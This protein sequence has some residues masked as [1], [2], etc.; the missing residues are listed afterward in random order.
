MHMSLFFLK[1]K[2]GPSTS[3]RDGVT[4][5]GFT[6]PL[7]TTIFVSKKKDK[8][9]ETTVFGHETIDRQRMISEKRETLHDEP[10]Y[11]LAYCLDG[12]SRL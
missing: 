3:G 12:V 8:I 2:G 7:Y 4:G 10:Y 6:L 11:H 9:Y 5:T 1:R